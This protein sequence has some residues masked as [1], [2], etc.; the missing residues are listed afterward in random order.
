MANEEVFI[1]VAN[2]NKISI[3]WTTT[4]SSCWMINLVFAHRLV[5]APR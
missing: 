3:L 5:I 2:A 1:S 4:S